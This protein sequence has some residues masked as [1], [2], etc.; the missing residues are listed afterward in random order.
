MT[1][2][3]ALLRFDAADVL[4]GSVR[5]AGGEVWGIGDLAF[6]LGYWVAGLGQG[7]S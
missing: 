1:D 5:F 6:L 2:V 3:D 4:E 7:L